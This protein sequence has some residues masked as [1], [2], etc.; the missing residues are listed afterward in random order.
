MAPVLQ[1]APGVSVKEVQR[2]KEFLGL[3]ERCGVDVGGEEGEGKEMSRVV[4]MWC[5]DERKTLSMKVM[6]P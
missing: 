1:K 2:D 6:V 5:W 4:R 3:V